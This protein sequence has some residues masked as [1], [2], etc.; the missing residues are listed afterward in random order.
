M[1]QH[2]HL[3][4]INASV[5][6]KR[7]SR[8][9]GRP[10]TLATIPD[11]EWQLLANRGFDLVWLMGIWQRSR[12][13]RQK[14]LT[15]PTLRQEY[16]KALPGWSEDDVD[17]SPYAIYSYSLNP[18]LGESTELSQLKSKLNQQGLQLILDFVP[19]HLALDHPWTISHPTW[20][21]QGKKEDAHTHP[22]QFFISEQGS[23]FAHGRDPNFPPWTDTVQV[24]FYSNELRQALIN[25]LLGIAELADGVR[26][27]MAMLALNDVFE[28]MWGEYTRDY[29]KP[30]TEFWS[31][32]ITRIKERHPRFLFI[33]EVYWGLERR[34]QEMGFDYTY[35]K[36]FYDK[37]RFSSS[38]EICDYLK[39]DDSYSRRSVRFIENHDEIRAVATFGRERSLAAAVVLSTMPGL[40]LFHD[41]QL[42]GYRIRLPIQLLRGPEEATDTHIAEFYEQ[43]LHVCNSPVFHDGQWLLLETSQAEQRDG[44]HCDLLAWW[45]RYADQTK[46]VVVN[47]SPKQNSCWLKLP[48]PLGP[49]GRIL[50]RDELTCTST[51]Q[52]TRRLANQDLHFNLKPWEAQILDVTVTVGN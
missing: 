5:L 14:A 32:A 25:E 6:I 17:G 26:C 39:A 23:C 1:R 18:L 29:Q 37:L 16:D 20:F 41:G 4:E 47:Y 2:P 43:L 21:V 3:Y 33:A 45:W 40:R 46:I 30:D 48:L 8:K 13:A 22:D 9:Y 7:M 42:E 28:R 31:E 51:V 10:M 38:Q 36:P 12:G 35:D 50:L 44:S 49:N 27:D 15:E 52:D 19:N 24:N 34:L 11:E